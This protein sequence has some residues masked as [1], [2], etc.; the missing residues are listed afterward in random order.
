MR[1][2]NGKSIINLLASVLFLCITCNVPVAAADVAQDPEQL[3]KH[4]TSSVMQELKA[5]Q[6]ELA[7][8]PHMVFGL[9]DKIV[10]PYVDFTEMGTWIA[11]RTAWHAATEGEKDNFIKEFKNLLLKTYAVA[12]NKYTN[13]T[14]EVYP[15]SQGSA[16]KGRVQISSKVIRTNQD[17]IKIDYRL[18]KHGDSWMLYDV[19]IEGVSIL[20]GFQ[21]QFSQDIKL[22][23]LG[24]V[25]AQIKE[26]NQQYDRQHD[27]GKG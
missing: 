26:H 6:T 10:L 5:N 7:S 11:G 20:K 16:S 12:L 3:I 21:A 4:I 13:E 24:Y 14:I 23:G 19:I 27:N 1:K 22:H 8:H 2:I 25:T 18:L 17:N 15:L 9:V